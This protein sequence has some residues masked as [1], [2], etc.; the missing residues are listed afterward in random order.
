MIYNGYFGFN[1]PPFR[2]DL[3]SQELFQAPRLDELHTRLRYLV[4]TCA[5][6][7]LTGEPGCGKSTASLWPEPF[8]SP[9]LTASSRQY[10]NSL[11][12]FLAWWLLVATLQDRIRV[13]SWK[14]ITGGAAEQWP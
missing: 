3:P 5:I 11:K 4:D 9:G 14:Q 6:G 1:Q 10:L 8:V 12:Y 7:L 2:R 13:N